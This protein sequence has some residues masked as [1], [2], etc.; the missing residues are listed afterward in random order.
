MNRTPIATRRTALPSPN[1]AVGKKI[2]MPAARLFRPFRLRT[3]MACISVL[4]LWVQVGRAQ[5]NDEADE[6]RPDRWQ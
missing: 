5:G 4:L 3:G 6:A 2:K 1:L